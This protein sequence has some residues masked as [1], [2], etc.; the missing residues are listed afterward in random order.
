MYNHKKKK[1]QIVN[2]DCT[3]DVQYIWLYTFYF[4][5]TETKKKTKEI[6][7]SDLVF[8]RLTIIEKEN[9]EIKDFHHHGILKR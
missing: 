8:E 3:M 2:Q 1:K 7:K 9:N 4:I 6:L 5:V